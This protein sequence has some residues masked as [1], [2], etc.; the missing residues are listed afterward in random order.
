MDWLP[1]GQNQQ[2]ITE[3]KFIF[4]AVSGYIAWNRT[5][6]KLLHSDFFL[7][8]PTGITKYCYVVIV[9]LP[10]TD[11]LSIAMLL[12]FWFTLDSVTP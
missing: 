4:S 3:E 2:T 9:L 10:W 5:K 6:N 7:I 8:L 11:L 1:S 12:L